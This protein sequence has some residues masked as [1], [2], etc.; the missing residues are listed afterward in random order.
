MAN[1][2]EVLVTMKGSSINATWKAYDVSELS[3]VMRIYPGAQPLQ[4]PEI[5]LTF[6]SLKEFEQTQGEIFAPEEDL[7]L[8][9]TD[10]R[11]VYYDN[12]ETSV[13]NEITGKYEYTELGS[14]D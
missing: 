12:I 6:E 9:W 2:E 1:D 10:L 8:G 3:P 14:T 13:T 5:I 11:K 4:I 7:L